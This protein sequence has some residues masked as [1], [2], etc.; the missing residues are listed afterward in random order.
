MFQEFFSRRVLSCVFQQLGKKTKITL[1][2]FVLFHFL[3]EYCIQEE[4][5]YNKVPCGNI[6]AILISWNRKWSFFPSLGSISKFIRLSE[7]DSL[8]RFFATSPS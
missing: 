5:F 4:F 2:G 3:G 8:N 1:E 6:H 7:G